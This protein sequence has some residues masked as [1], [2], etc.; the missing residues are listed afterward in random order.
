MLLECC[1]VLIKAEQA[2]NEHLQLSTEM[3]E[4]SLLGWNFQQHYNKICDIIH[5][6]EGNSHITVIL[7]QGT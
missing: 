2:F 4:V 7:S 3:E 1:S 5:E 6:T